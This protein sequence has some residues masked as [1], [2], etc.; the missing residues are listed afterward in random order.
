MAVSDMKDT[1][2]K[3]RQR[4]KA[5]GFFAFGQRVLGLNDSVRFGR[6]A[7][8]FTVAALCLMLLSSLATAIALHAAGWLALPA[9]RPLQ[10]QAST[11]DLPSDAT[12]ASRVS[13]PSTEIRPDNAAANA[14]TPT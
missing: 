10:I 14:R 13:T 12:C 6:L 2:P 8:C 3:G 11:T 1:L 9:S 4:K 7:V 5:R